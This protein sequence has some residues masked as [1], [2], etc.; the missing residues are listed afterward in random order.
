MVACLRE[1]LFG[2]PAYRPASLAAPSTPAATSV[3]TSAARGSGSAAFEGRLCGAVGCGRLE[4]GGVKFKNC[5][6]CGKFTYCSRECQM[7][8]WPSH[9]LTCPGSTGGKGGGSSSSSGMAHG[10]LC[11][12]I[13][14][15]HVCL[16]PI[17]CSCV[18][19]VV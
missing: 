17:M 16:P 18:A 3:N 11:D 9:T 12:A 2:E 14:C 7:A 13:I 4:G 5:S 10:L 8:H 1:M 6:A 15:I 19:C